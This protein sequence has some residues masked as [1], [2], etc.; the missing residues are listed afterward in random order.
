MDKWTR[1]P[2]QKIIEKTSKALKANGIDAIVDEKERSSRSFFNSNWNRSVW[3][4]KGPKSNW[5]T[6]KDPSLN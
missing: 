3:K 5:V 2:N 4:P 1:I 6:T